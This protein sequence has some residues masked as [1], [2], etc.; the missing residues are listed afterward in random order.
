M[1]AASYYKPGAE[2][3]RAVERR[4]RR[5]QSEYQAGARRGDVLAGAQPGLG[6]VS[7]K[8]A[9]LGPVWDLT[10]G[11]YFEG[12][13]GI[14]KL[15]SQMTDSWATKQVLATGRPPG[16]GER[17]MTTGLL[18][19]RLSTAIVKANLSVLMGRLGMVG[20]G[21]A[22]ARGRRQWG[23]MEE[24]RMRRERE[25]AWRADTTGREVVRRGRFWLQ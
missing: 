22:M 3:Q 16:E 11:G 6:P 4:S 9:E 8:L 12:S 2:G 25:A 5:I 20:E 13:A 18:R 1:G 7:Q 15:V 21:A 14:H 23:R 19:R 17:S 24:E 10:T